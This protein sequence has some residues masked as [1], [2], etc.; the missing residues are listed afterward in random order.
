MR[1]LQIKQDTAKQLR[2]KVSRHF[3]A[4]ERLRIETPGGGGGRPK[5][6]NQLFA[7]PLG[8]EKV[9]GDCQQLRSD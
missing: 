7:Q 4:G 5:Q 1:N 3:S 6:L 2:G 8:G 9:P